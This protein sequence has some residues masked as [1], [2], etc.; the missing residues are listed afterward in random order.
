MINNSNSSR[1]TKKEIVFIS[2]ISEHIPNITSD[3]KP[4]ND[5]DDIVITTLCCLILFNKFCIILYFMFIFEKL[6]FIVFDFAKHNDAK[7]RVF[8][9][10]HK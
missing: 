10:R 9:I 2:A 4:S 3:T 7:I 5:N 8:Y 1:R 6:K